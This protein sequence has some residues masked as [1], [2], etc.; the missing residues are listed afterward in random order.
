MPDCTGAA[1]RLPA[2]EPVNV[3]DYEQA[4]LERS[5]RG[6]SAT[7]PA[8]P[9]MSARCARTLRRWPA[10]SCAPRVLVDVT[11]WMLPRRCSGLLSRCRCWSRRSRSRASRMRRASRRAPAPRRRRARSS[12]LSTLAS[13][14]PSDVAPRPA[15]RGCSCTSSRSRASPRRSSTRRVASGFGALVLTVDAPRAGRRERDLRSGFQLPP[16]IERAQCR[17]GDRAAAHPR[18]L[19]RSSSCRRLA[20]LGGARASLRASPLPVV[21]KGIQSRGRRPA[22]LRARR[23]SRRRLKPRW[24]TARRCARRRSRPLAGDRRTPSTAGSR[25]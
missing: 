8:A 21:L 16:G 23:G 10:S 14:A 15:R 25:C 5:S 20:E 9:E 11:R 1:G 2:V 7:S 12:C 17:G 22:G 13:C 6:H 4:A 24:P 19:P 3:P 18:R